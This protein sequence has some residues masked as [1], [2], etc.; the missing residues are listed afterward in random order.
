MKLTRAQKLVRR[1]QQ[2]DAELPLDDAEVEATLREFGLDLEKVRREAQ[3]V[4]ADLRAQS[5]RRRRAMFLRRASAAVAVAAAALLVAWVLSRSGQLPTVSQRGSSGEARPQERP[6]ASRYDPAEW[7]PSGKTDDELALPGGTPPLKTPAT[8]ADGHLEIKVTAGA[9]PAAKAHV[10]LYLRGPR[11]PSTSNSEWRFAGGGVTGADGRLRVPARFGSYLVAVRADGYAAA[12]REVVRPAGEPLTRLEVPLAGGETLRGRTLQKGTSEALPMAEL[13]LSRL[14]ANGQGQSDSPGEETLYATSDA[15]GRFE[16]RGVEPGEY[17]LQASAPGHAT[18]RR[19]VVI[20]RNG[21]LTLSLTAAATLSGR[22]LNSK[23]TGAALAEVELT[24]GLDDARVQRVT[25][26]PSGHF[27]VELPA[28]SYK[29][30]ARLGQEAGAADKAVLLAPGTSVEGV[31]VRLG[32]G[33]AITGVV[34]AKT[35][36]ATLANAYLV[37]SPPAGA[38]DLGHTSSGPDG[39]FALEPLTAGVYDVEVYLEG[40]SPFLRRGVTLTAGQ[41]FPL[42]IEL[43]GTG[44]VQ[45][46]VRDAAGAPVAGAILQ[47]ALL[48]GGPFYWGTSGQARSAADG[49]YRLTGL[50]VG[51]VRISVGRVPDAWLVREFAEVHEGQVAKLD[52]TLNELGTVTG[53]VTREGGRPLEADAVVRATPEDA[54]TMAADA[55]QT[56]V[57]RDGRYSLSLPPGRYAVRA[58]KPEE[59]F[60]RLAGPTTV[61]E[62]GKTV[63]QDL[64]LPDQPPEKIVSGV[65]LEPSGMPAAGAYVAAFGTLPGGGRYRVM[66]PCDE[67]GH[68]EL[69]RLAGKEPPELLEVSARRGGRTALVPGVRRGAKELTVR[70]GPGGAITG[71]VEG[72]A[73]TTVLVASQVVDERLMPF[74]SGDSREFAGDSFQLEDVPAGR[75]RVSA[76]VADGRTGSAEVVVPAGGSARVTLTL[77]PMAAISGMIL[78]DGDK[79]LSGALVHIDDDGAYRPTGPDGIFR[80]S[81]LEAGTHHLSVSAAGYQAL[82]KELLVKPG[83]G[84]ELGAVRLSRPPA[85]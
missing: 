68:F 71:R 40:F 46:V 42:V 20:P 52:F 60:I 6:S 59:R 48:F 16:L 18:L 22:V 54:M 63:E 72:A 78:G 33:G 12:R 39:S 19:E 65:V 77:S 31:L 14:S 7:A 23:G 34:K 43:D 61:I 56:R 44:E 76:S 9:E 51:K 13:S 49:S 37:L 4:S 66:M 85:K 17:D 64:Q 27:A 2:V 10:R 69:L 38:G 79:P 82:E 24:G 21:E 70:L 50:Q 25:A 55:R 84:L 74:L 32:A 45:G 73:S 83:Q 15:H 29:V 58:F 62:P 35:T 57:E 67:S 75:V 26:G 5:Q 41:R 8:E 36:Q 47:G 11:D 3:Q 30:A 53:R 80:I 28:G 1:M 81:E